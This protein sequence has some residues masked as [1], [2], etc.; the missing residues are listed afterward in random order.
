MFLPESRRLPFLVAG[1]MPAAATLPA[2]ASGAGHSFSALYR[3]TRQE[4]SDYIRH[5]ESEAMPALSPDGAWLHSR[6]AMQGALGAAR[7]ISQAGSAEDFANAV[8]PYARQAASTLGVAPEI[9][10]AHA[11][12]ESDWGRRPIVREDGSHSF[13]LFGIKA[14]EGWQGERTRSVTHEFVDGQMRKSVEPFRAYPDY[15]AAFNDYARLISSNPRYRAALG[16]G[17]D[18]AAYARALAQGGYATDPD[19]AAKLSSVVASL[20]QRQARATTPAG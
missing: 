12:L 15:A 6:L 4:V 16:V 11:A 7:T 8:L 10:A 13:N 17:S 2:P 9:I 5:G 20:R 1:E 14:G 3:Q 18:G 19:Y